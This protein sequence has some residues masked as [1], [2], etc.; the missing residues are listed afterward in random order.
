MSF[1]ILHFWLFM[2]YHIV[3]QLFHTITMRYSVL[4][5]CCSHSI[6]GVINHAFLI[7]YTISMR[8]LFIFPLLSFYFSI[9]HDFLYYFLYFYILSIF[10]YYP[11]NSLN[12][13]ILN[14]FFLNF[15][16]IYDVYCN[17]FIIPMRC[18]MV[19]FG[20]FNVR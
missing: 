14:V 20:S 13:F 3:F 6:Y 17:V 7:I 10:F 9:L 15:I 8:F 1:F 18:S 4:Y 12:L 2:W 19:Y 5:F 11:F 16:F